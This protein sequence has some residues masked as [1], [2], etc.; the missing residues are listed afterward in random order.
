MRGGWLKL[1][2]FLAAAA[3]AAP[4]CAR[5]TTTPEPTFG[6]DYTHYSNLARQIE[7]PDEPT[8]SDDVIAS[9]S[10]PMTLATPEAQQYLDLSLE[11]TMHLALANSRLMRDLG[12]L[13][14]RAPD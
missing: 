2:R 9:T 14:L 1:G 10:A 4:G 3:L 11:E 7:F 5:Y 13:V 8:P 12:G 6:V